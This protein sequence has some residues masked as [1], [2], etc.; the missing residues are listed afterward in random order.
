M[1][2]TYATRR[3]F[4][5]RLFRA[6][7]ATAA[8]RHTFLDGLSD[9]A[10]QAQQT[11]G[12]IQSTSANGASV[13]FQFFDGWSPDV[14][15]SLIDEART[16]ADCA[17]VDTALALLPDGPVTSFGHDFTLSNATGGTL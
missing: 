7:G 5:R 1:G 3:E 17:D 12:S 11:G 8:L 16:W 15:L 4:C 9:T 2:A 13:A 14:A 6:G 10:I